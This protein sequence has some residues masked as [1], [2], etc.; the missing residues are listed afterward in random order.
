MAQH[1]NQKNSRNWQCRVT[2]W[3]HHKAM[4]NS[5]KKLNAA[6]EKEKGQATYWNQ[7]T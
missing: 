3:V 1:C 7:L 6:R 2:H 5:I 4:C